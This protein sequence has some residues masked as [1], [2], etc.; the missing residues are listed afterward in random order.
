MWVEAVSENQM[1]YWGHCYF[2]DSASEHVR[3][4]ELLSCS[5]HP[6]A[7]VQAALPLHHTSRSD[8]LCVV[9]RNYDQVFSPS[10][11]DFILLVQEHGHQCIDVH[12]AHG[13]RC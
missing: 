5:P 12:K 6:G 13:A 11:A 3:F 8:S 9:T 2:D 4:Y 10:S 1:R 7:S